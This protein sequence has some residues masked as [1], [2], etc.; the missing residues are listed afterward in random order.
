MLHKEIAKYC[1]KKSTKAVQKIKKLTKQKSK[2]EKRRNLL[3]KK[4]VEKLL[5]TT[6]LLN[7]N[8][9]IKNH[10]KKRQKTVFSVC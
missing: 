2:S 7:E 10:K 8:K 1:D 3:Q 6:N 5:K 4:S 9:I